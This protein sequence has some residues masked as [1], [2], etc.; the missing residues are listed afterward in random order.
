MLK[1]QLKA[2][3]EIREK[4]RMLAKLRQMQTRLIDALALEQIPLKVCS[5][6]RSRR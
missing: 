4:E 3:R 5:R 2:I 1:V 6:F